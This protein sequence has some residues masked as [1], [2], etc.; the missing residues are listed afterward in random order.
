MRH[1]AVCVA[2]MAL[3]ALPSGPAGAEESGLRYVVVTT[4]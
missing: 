2:V 1:L 4:L 3:V